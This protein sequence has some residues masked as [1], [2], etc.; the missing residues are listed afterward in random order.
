MS[1]RP[2]RLA[3]FLIEEHIL[4]AKQARSQEEIETRMRRKKKRRFS[5]AKEVAPAST[6][7]AEQQLQ[8]APSRGVG[9]G[10]GGGEGEVE[11]DGDGYLEGSLVLSLFGD[12]SSVSQVFCSNL[13]TAACQTYL[14]GVYPSAAGVVSSAGSLSLESPPPQIVSLFSCWISS[15]PL[16]PLHCLLRASEEEGQ[17]PPGG[18]VRDSGVG[19]LQVFR[20]FTFQLSLPDYASLDVGTICTIVAFV[21]FSR[22]LELVSPLI[23]AGP[24]AVVRAVC[25]SS[26]AAGPR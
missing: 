17:L 25:A 6:A 1:E 26:A 20:D 4:L 18:Q 24:C 23:A 12:F 2:L 19:K 7:S 10:V 16:L 21:L 22:L 11:E 8:A 9:V 13:M 3:R 5:S 14:G 15:S